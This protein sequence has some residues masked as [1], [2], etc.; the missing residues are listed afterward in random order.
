MLENASTYA[1]F[2]ASSMPEWEFFGRLMEE[3]DCGM[4]L[5]VNNV[6]VSAFNHGF[7]PKR[8]LDAID[9]SR[10]DAVPPGRPHEQGH[11]HRRH[12]QRPRDPGGLGALSP[13]GRADRQRLD[14]AS[15]GTATSRRSKSCTP[16][17]FRRGG[18]G[19]TGRRDALPP[20]P[21]ELPLPRL[22]RWMQAVIEQP[23]EADGGR[24]VR[25]G[26]RRARSGGHRPRH[27]ALEDAHLG[28]ARRRLSG[29]VSA[30]DGRSPRE[31]LP[32]RGPPS[33]RRR[34]RRARH[35]LCRRTPVAQLHAQPAGR[36]FSRVRSDL[37]R[38]S[39]EGVRGRSRAPRGPRHRGLRRPGIAGAGRSRRSRA[40]PSRPGKAP[41]SGRSTRCGWA[42]S[43]TPSTRTCSR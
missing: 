8:Y 10:V 12:A 6:Y 25:G 32:G 31:R 35:G 7:D 3:A 23:G 37:A 24:D 19:A 40:S 17:R 36:P 16:R 34:L 9:P 26:A 39:A 14:A 20:S 41:C 28:R 13:L 30:E 27:P 11:A 2:A 22:Q 33:R 21:L 29:H 15:S 5:D 38:P 18:S 4:L 1:E 43:R 42:P